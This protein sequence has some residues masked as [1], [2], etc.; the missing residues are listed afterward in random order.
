MSTIRA[1][2]LVNMDGVTAVTLAR[3]VAAKSWSTFN[4][5][6]ASVYGS[7]NVSS[8]TRISTG[9]YYVNMSNAM[10]DSNY[11]AIAGSGNAV[12]SFSTGFC[13]THPASTTV[14][15]IGKFQ[16]AFQDD[17]YIFSTVLR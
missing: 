5:T 14:Q 6:N 7:F 12:G 10:V 15:Y 11:N 8:V 1:N 4:G 17:P 13:A 2:T 9:Q 16:S 3:Q